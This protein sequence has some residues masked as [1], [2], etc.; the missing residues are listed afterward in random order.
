VVI[1]GGNIFRGGSGRKNLDRSLCRHIRMLATIINS[2]YFKARSGKSR[3]CLLRHER[4]AVSESS[5]NIFHR[6]AARRHCENG[7]VSSSR[8]APATPTLHRHRRC[9][10]DALRSKPR[11]AQATKVDGVYDSDPVKNPAER[12]SKPSH[13]DAR[14]KFPC[15]GQPRLPCAWKTIYRSLFSNCSNRIPRKCVER[16]TAGTIVK[17]GV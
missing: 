13:S 11:P 8:A 2:L 3:H 12:N 4:S 1:G 14:R 7:E 9:A 10:A 17:K 5:T 15:H 6:R 16:S